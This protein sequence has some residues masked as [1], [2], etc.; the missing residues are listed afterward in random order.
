MIRYRHGF[1]AIITSYF[2]SL[3]IAFFNLHFLHCIKPSTSSR[4]ARKQAQNLMEGQFIKHTNLAETL[5]DR[6]Y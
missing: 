4:S 5:W 3:H 6:R 1:R 2:L